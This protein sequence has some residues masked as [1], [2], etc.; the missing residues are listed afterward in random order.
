MVPYRECAYVALARRQRIVWQRPDPVRAA[1][2][3]ENNSRIHREPWIANDGSAVEGTTDIARRRGTAP[4][5]MADLADQ[6]STKV[7]IEK[8]P[9]GIEILVVVRRQFCA[10]VLGE[11]LGKG[12]HLGGR[13]V[14]A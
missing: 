9:T 6:S 10:A 11:T 2:I 5:G 8:T 12:D 4:N 1:S 3:M 13:R 7:L 14:C